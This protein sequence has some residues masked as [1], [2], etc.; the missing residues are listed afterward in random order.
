MDETSASENRATKTASLDS[1]EL[2]PPNLIKADVEGVE[3]KVFKG[4]SQLLS[5]H[6]PMLVFENNRR[7]DN[8]WSTLEPL[9]LLRGL[10]YEFSPRGL[11]ARLRPAFVYGW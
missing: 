10:G 5:E 3:T 9:A 4:G 7:M 11:A 2:P 1:L 8:P 6:K